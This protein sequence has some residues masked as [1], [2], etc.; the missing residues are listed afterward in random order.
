MSSPAR[1][2][3]VR[4]GIASAAAVLAIVLLHDGIEARERAEAAAQRLPMLPPPSALAGLG[5]RVAPVDG[6][7]ALARRLESLRPDAAP[8]YQ[9]LADGS[10]ALRR[11]APAAAAPAAPTGGGVAVVLP[12]GPLAA[13]PPATRGAFGELLAALVGERPVP[14][15]RLRLVDAP[16]TEAELRAV[17]AWLP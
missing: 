16:L 3:A 11:A 7:I 12:A 5:V 1:G 10:L 4:L 13:W 6:E 17:L 2:L 9:V 14:R 8:V 15:A